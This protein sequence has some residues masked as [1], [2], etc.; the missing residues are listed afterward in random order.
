MAQGRLILGPNGLEPEFEEPAE[1]EVAWV[2]TDEPFEEIQANVHLI[3][4]APDLLRLAE[5]MLSG[6][7]NRDELAAVIR[8]AKGEDVG[9][10]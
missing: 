3:A 5:Q 6:E 4:A 8:R 1:I 7:V 10:S 9:D 2:A